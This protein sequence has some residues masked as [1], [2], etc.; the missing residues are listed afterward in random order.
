[1]FVFQIVLMV[2]VF[3]T[4]TYWFLDLINCNAF[5]FIRPMA[6]SI[7]D[8]V[9]L[10]YFEDIEIGGVYID[11]SLLLF[12][13]L[14]LIAVF[15][16]TKAKF[17]IYRFIEKL[18]FLVRKRLNENE[19]KFNEQLKQE[20][21]EKIKT[22]NNV[23]ILVKFEAKNIVID[24]ESSSE[25]KEKKE[26][27]KVEDAFK[28]FYSALKALSGCKFAKTDDK[29]LILTDSFSRIDNLLNFVDLSINRIR[30]NMKNDK[31]RL[32][33]FIA[34]DVYGRGENFKQSVYPILEKLL[35]L[36]HRNEALCLGNFKLRYML[37]E[38]NMYTFEAKGPHTIVEKCDVFSLVKK[39]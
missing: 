31:W 23:A 16:I 13:I 8:F 21:E 9:R 37:N 38:E 39:N 26:Q 19:D 14:S 29:I 32:Y 10:F 34:I 4:A 28:I 3:L 1:M 15:F 27:A 5:D 35:V 24:Y 11:G 33:S 20:I 6:G 25:E 22:C 12:D 18:Q 30:E 7:S 17:Y 36:R 2:T